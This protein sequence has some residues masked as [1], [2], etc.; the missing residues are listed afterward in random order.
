MRKPRKLHG[1]V[2]ADYLGDLD[3]KRSMTGYV[4]IVTE[5]AISWKAELQDMRFI[6]LRITG[7]TS[8]RSTLM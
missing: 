7:I 3:Q 5:C 8:G 6:S 1:Y 2:D 4:F